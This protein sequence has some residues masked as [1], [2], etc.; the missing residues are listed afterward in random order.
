MRVDKVINRGKIISFLI[1]HWGEYYSYSEISEKIGGINGST[2][3]QHLREL[4]EQGI[5][6]ST[7]K[8]GKPIRFGLNYQKDWKYKWEQDK[9]VTNM[10]TNSNFNL[11]T[12]KE[13]KEVE[14]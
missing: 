9:N 2:C 7:K 14:E 8:R 6:L 4:R 1:E 10:G 13:I 3:L 11:L 12:H 5:V